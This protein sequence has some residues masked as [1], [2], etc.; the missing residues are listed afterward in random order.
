MF[1]REHFARTL[2]HVLSSEARVA[3]HY[4]SVLEEVEDPGLRLALVALRQEV[5][6]RTQILHRLL[7][8]LDR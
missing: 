4:E 3:A 1:S 2:E 8:R 5:V 6:R 7:G